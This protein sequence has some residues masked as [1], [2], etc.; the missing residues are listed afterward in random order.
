MYWAR[1]EL[2]A[3]SVQCRFRHVALFCWHAGF[4]MV[5]GGLEPSQGKVSNFY[6]MKLMALQDTI[7]Q[8]FRIALRVFCLFLIFYVGGT[9]EASPTITEGR[10]HQLHWVL[11]AQLFITGYFISMFASASALTS[12]QFSAGAL[13]EMWLSHAQG[14]GGGRILLSRSSRSNY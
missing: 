1:E 2:L 9:P 10:Q 12:V 7:L 11:I 14:V 3:F 8:T 5:C 4:F 13:P 6:V